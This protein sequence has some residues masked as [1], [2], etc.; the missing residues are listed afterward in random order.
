MDNEIGSRE[1]EM[2]QDSIRD[3]FKGVHD[4]L[5][6]VNGRLDKHDMSINTLTPDVAGH[7]AQLRNLN[8]EVFDR[9]RRASSVPDE[10]DDLRPIA[11]RDLRT[12]VIG[13]TTVLAAIA[14]LIKYGPWILKVISGGGE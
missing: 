6:R 11:V 9:P 1:F 12:V 3:G 10:K 4:R 5:D 14:A 2:L 13:A 7:T 8:R